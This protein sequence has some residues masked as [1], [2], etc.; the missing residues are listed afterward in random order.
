[1][2]NHNTYLYKKSSFCDLKCHSLLTCF[3][4]SALGNLGRVNSANLNAHS[5]RL[6]D[7][8]I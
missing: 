3:S 8:Q 1:M 4:K 2:L 6:S 5:S 7:K